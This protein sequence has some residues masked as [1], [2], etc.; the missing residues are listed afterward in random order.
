MG[1]CDCLWQVAI[2]GNKPSKFRD[3]GLTRKN[4]N[5]KGCTDPLMLIVF[6][7]FLIGL[8]IVAEWSF[9]HGSGNRYFYGA[10]SWD[11]ICGQDNSGRNGFLLSENAGLDMRDRPHQYYTNPGDRKAMVLCVAACPDQEEYTVPCKDEKTND[12]S[13]DC[14]AFCLRAPYG[15]HNASEKDKFGTNALD[16]S[17]GGC[18]DFIRRTYNSGILDRCIPKMGGV[19]ED[20]AGETLAGWVE[21]VNAQSYFQQAYQ[22]VAASFAIIL[23]CLAIAIAISYIMIFIM[24]F[25]VEPMI[26]S[27][28]ILAMLGLIVVT[29]LLWDQYQTLDDDLSKTYANQTLESDTRNRDAFQVLAYMMTVF[30]IV[31]FLLIVAIRRSIYTAAKI[32]KQAARALQTMPSMMLVPLLTYAALFA[33]LAYWIV[34]LLYMASTDVPELMLTDSSVGQGHVLYKEQEDYR[35]FWWYHVFGLFW[36]Y[37]FILASAE[38]VLA[39]CV[40]MWYKWGEEPP[41]YAMPRSLYRLVRHHLGTVALGSLIIAIC[42][43]AQAVLMYVKD[44]ADNSKSSVAKAAQFFIK[45]CFCCF[46][47]LEKCL[48]YINRNAYVEV[49][50]YGYSFGNAA[51]AAFSTI[52]A[53]ILQLATFNFIGYLVFFVLKLLITGSVC[54]IGYFWLDYYHEKTGDVPLWA[55]S[56]VI[57]GVATWFIAC[58]FSDL[59]EM[60]ADTLLICFCEDRERNKKSGDYLARGSTLKLL[61]HFT[62]KDHEKETDEKSREKAVKEASIY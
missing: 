26:Y 52:V 45:C 31:M 58:A 7:V 3:E 33:F 9:T 15:I 41:R 29:V 53:N 10:D 50:L 48:K 12:T 35:N 18:P 23:Y 27:M 40:T 30:T 59:Y 37:C 46:W 56:L 19:L 60:S 6:T 44:K 61:K 62:Y 47:C 2:G 55:L 51:W 21:A 54:V 16:R 38:M 25:I 4:S 32:Y 17:N 39:G 5:L 28:F 14:T 13:V 20:F 1:V 36:M 57:I 11:N 34:V 24:R 8:G 49:S 43:F 42:Q 22:S